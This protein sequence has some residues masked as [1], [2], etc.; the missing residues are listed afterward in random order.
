LRE[1]Q[2]LTFLELFLEYGEKVAQKSP[3]F[4]LPG[5][6]TGKTLFESCCGPPG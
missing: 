2:R 4:R 6:E 3:Q 1:E 5:L